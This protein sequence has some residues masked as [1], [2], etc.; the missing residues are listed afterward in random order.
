VTGGANTPGVATD[1]K[2]KKERISFFGGEACRW[3]GKRAKI[4][5]SS[6]VKEEVTG[7]E[8]KGSAGTLDAEN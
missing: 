4:L 6:L 3:I 5:I 8:K 7:G 2:E 1:W